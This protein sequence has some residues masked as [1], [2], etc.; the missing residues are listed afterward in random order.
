MGRPGRKDQLNHTETKFLE[1]YTKTGAKT[2]LDATASY[3]KAFEAPHATARGNSY[4]VLKRPLVRKTLREML[5]ETDIR[6]KIQAGF[7]KIVDGFLDEDRYRAK[8][9]SEAARMVTEILGDKSPDKQVILNL[10]P[11]DRDRE[12]QEI[13]AKV[14]KLQNK[15]QA[16]TPTLEP[17][18]TKED[19]VPQT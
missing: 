16:T 8:D 11:E 19:A 15:T 9:F 7:Q 10:T 5:G 6:D 12:Y 14:L 18:P 4:K 17:E 1:A 13:T 3:E 2:Y